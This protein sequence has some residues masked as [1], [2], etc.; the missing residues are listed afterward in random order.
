MTYHESNE[1]TEAISRIVSRWGAEPWFVSALECRDDAGVRVEVKV[2]SAC[3]DRERDELPRK[4]GG[5]FMVVIVVDR[6]PGDLP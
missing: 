3:Y 1:T 6:S 4:Y 2:D 5:M